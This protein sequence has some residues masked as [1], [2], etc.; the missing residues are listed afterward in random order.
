MAVEKG[1]RVLC[2][3]GPGSVARGLGMQGEGVN[4][5]E[6][7]IRNL[8]VQ[9]KCRYKWIKWSLHVE[10]TKKKD[11]KKFCLKNRILCLPLALE[12]P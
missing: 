11:I 5:Y 12:R 1:S 2:S 7:V 4:H 6:K 3:P 8:V 9:V 10:I